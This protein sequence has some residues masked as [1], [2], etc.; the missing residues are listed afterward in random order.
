[1]GYLL[2]SLKTHLDNEENR[3][4]LSTD[5]TSLYTF[6]NVSSVLNGATT[7]TDKKTLT[8]PIGSSGS[9]SYL[10][11]RLM[12]NI[13]KIYGKKVVVCLNYTSTTD[14]ASKL[15]T[16]VQNDGTGVTSQVFFDS[17][18]KKAYF[19]IDI[20]SGCTATYIIPTLKIT[21]TSTYTTDQTISITSFT[22]NYYYDSDVLN[23]QFKNWY[24]KSIHTFGD[25]YTDQELWQ[26]TVVS[27]LALSGYTKDA[28]SGGTLTSIYANVSNIPVTKDI[29]LIWFGTNDFGG[30]RKVGT[31]NDDVSDASIL[32]S[33][34]YTTFMAALNYVCNWFATNMSAKKI[35]FLTPTQRFDGACDTFATANGYDSRGYV[36]NNAGFVLEDYANAIITIANKWGYSVCDLHH[37]SGINKLS[38]PSYYQADKLHPSA[39]GAV[40]LGSQIASF[41]NAH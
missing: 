31:F 23:T 5:I 27:K 26:P 38:Y 21:L 3:H 22:A 13:S 9:G 8:I 10:G 39:S 32:D 14:I 33:W 41:I 37:N 34:G 1:M 2:Q 35:I 30:N 12:S 4:N 16:L 20:A 19:I 40:L 24:G 36:K 18:N 15:G 6:D 11:V 29:V 7:S 25:S 28:V 17:V